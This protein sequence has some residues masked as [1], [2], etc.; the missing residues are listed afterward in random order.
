MLELELK[1][2]V[3]DL[4]AARQR[5]TRAGARLVYAGRL[6]DRR[7]DTEY[8]SL[9]MRDHVLRVRTYR[10]DDGARAT[11]DWKGPT[12]Y[13]GSYKAREELNASVADADALAQ[14]LDRLGYRVTMAIDREIWQYELG[15]ATVRFERYPRM[16]DL[17]EVE[18]APDAIEHAIATLALPR[19]DFTSERL[20]DFVARYEARAGHAAALSD[21]ELAGRVHYPH[22][23]A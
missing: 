7:Y 13:Q 4:D 2:V 18:G 11:I 9:Q 23:N 21:A 12:R 17:V 16:D 15:A 14:I 20:P 22:E 3:T 19:A 1:S 5:L 10:G 6:E 8:R